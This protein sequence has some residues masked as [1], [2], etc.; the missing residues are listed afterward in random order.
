MNIA[1]TALV[2][3][4]LAHGTLAGAEPA[5]ISD[6]LQAGLHE[7]PD[8]ASTVLMLLSSGTPVEVLEREGGLAR[9]RTESG[10]EGW[11]DAM[12]LSEEQPS[13]LLLAEVEAARAEAVAELEAAHE[14]IATLEADL[15]RV[16]A[17]AD[18]RE[19][20]EQRP[21]GGNGVQSA[22]F[23][24]PINSETL[25]EMQRLAE[26]NQRIKQQLAEAEATAT[27]ALEQLEAAPV[28]AAA[29]PAS[30]NAAQAHF[31][32]ALRHWNP[33]EWLALASTLLLAFGT[34]L[35]LSELGVRRRHGGFRL[36]V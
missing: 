31:L 2:A 32:L 5:W 10:S 25:R 34:G 3:A 36:R 15:E 33:W 20:D 14:H 21:A 19:A 22:S 18:V 29:E 35:W 27:M 30:A 16:A 1:R 23:E 11:V 26:E 6:R 8:P 12:Y 4:M 24:A 28:A 13:A 17:L 7:Q 9:V